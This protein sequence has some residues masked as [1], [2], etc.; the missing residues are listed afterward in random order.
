MSGGHGGRRPGAGRKL[1]VPNKNTAEIR[2]IAQSYGPDAITA[3][4]EMAGL[5]PG[6]RAEAETARIAALRAAHPGAD[7]QRRGRVSG[8]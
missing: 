5:A 6:R 3:L 7:R 4:A 2:T 8:R 1:G